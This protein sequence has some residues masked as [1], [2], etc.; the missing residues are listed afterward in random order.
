MS[1]GG[2]RSPYRPP[3]GYSAD[4]PERYWLG[5]AWQHY[6]TEDASIEKLQN[7]TSPTPTIQDTWPGP[8]A[9]VNTYAPYGPAEYVSR[10]TC[11]KSGFKT[12]F[13]RKFWQGRFGFTDGDACNS[14][15]RDGGPSSTKYCSMSWTFTATQSPTPTAT[16]TSSGSLTINRYSGRMTGSFSQELSVD[17]D[18]TAIDF[19]GFWSGG[20]GEFLSDAWTL[21]NC[22]GVWSGENGSGIVD[23]LNGVTTYGWT[24]TTVDCSADSID[25]VLSYSGTGPAVTVNISISLGDAYSSSDVDADVES[26]LAYWNLA[27]D[28]QIPFR[29]D[30]YCTSG[31]YL[32]Y[33]EYTANTLGGIEAHDTLPGD[34]TSGTETVALTDPSLTG[35]CTFTWTPATSGDDAGIG[36][37]SCSAS[38]TFSDGL[39]YTGNVL[40]APLCASECD[41]AYGAYWDSNYKVWSPSGMDDSWIVI[42]YGAFNNGSA[43]TGGIAFPNATQWTDKND[44]A[45]LLPGAFAAYASATG[46]GGLVDGFNADARYLPGYL[47]KSKYAEVILLTAPSHDFARPCGTK[48]EETIDQTTIPT[49]YGPDSPCNL[50]SLRW[51]GVM[52]CPVPPATNGQWNDNRPKGDWILASWSTNFRSTEGGAVTPSATQQ[53]SSFVPCCPAVVYLT[54]GG[55]TSENSQTTGIDGFPSLPGPLGLDDCYGALWQM[56]PYQWMG[57]P[58]WQVP[59]MSE[60]CHLAGGQWHEDD[61]SGLPDGDGIY[62]YPQRPREEARLT[63]PSGAPALPGGCALPTAATIPQPLGGQCFS[64]VWVWDL[65]RRSATRFSCDYADPFA[66]CSDDAEIEPP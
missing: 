5:A 13:A 43:T 51:S 29:T 19:T 59:A 8:P 61:G 56:N 4:E 46:G 3:C 40:G 18:I 1:V 34:F 27:D 66:V 24:I 57:D 41:Y 31:P 42:G 36:P 28:V 39:T 62:Y 22:S 52:D 16:Y 23:I 54:N 38:G 58:L 15:P 50:G 9:L 20:L 44:S 53:C 25:I 49:C 17:N 2:N 6:R 26:L 12:V 32:S 63:V 11:R 64:P 37:A 10:A 60:E 45:S 33:D 21:R 55:E 30:P 48:D 35:T 14:C 47:I 7:T 65:N